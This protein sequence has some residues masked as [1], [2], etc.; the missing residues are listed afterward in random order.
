MNIWLQ[1]EERDIFK[2]IQKTIFNKLFFTG[3]L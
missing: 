3:Y 2:G 1:I